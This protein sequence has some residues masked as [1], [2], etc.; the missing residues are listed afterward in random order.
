M[1]NTKLSIFGRESAIRF[2]Q[3]KHDY[4]TVIISIST[5]DVDYEESPFISDENKVTEILGLSFCDADY[6][7]T[8]D[9]YGKITSESEL[10]N[11]EDAD[12]VVKFTEKHIGKHIIVH[13]DAG[14]SRSSGV[15]AAILKH[16]NGDD[17]AVFDSRWYA[18]NRWCY[19][20]VLEAFER[21]SD[22]ET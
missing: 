22:N 4:E 14:I 6:P 8:K 2:C 9:V 17:S 20:K 12:R 3:K 1:N 16:Y 18:P 5:P 7:N 11:D 10:M 19:R 21:L 13:C 15:A